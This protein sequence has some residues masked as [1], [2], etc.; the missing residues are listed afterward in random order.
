ML[1]TKV[2]IEGEPRGLDLDHDAMPGDE[3]V[4]GVGQVE[5]V[6][7]GRVGGDGVGGGEGFAVAAAEDV[8]G[9]HELVAAHMWV[10]GDFIWVDVDELDD[11]VGV[12]AGG[13]GDQVGNR[14][15]GDGEGGGGDGGGER[16]GNGGPGLL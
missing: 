11:P 5:A 13:G 9:D 1:G 14:L 3:D 12:C 2:I 16:G 6:R 4:V 8:G 15:A 10:P 7:F